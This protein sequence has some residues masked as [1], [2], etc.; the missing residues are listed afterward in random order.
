MPQLRKI[1]C[2]RVGHW[3]AR[4]DGLTLDFCNDGRP[5]DT[6]LW[7]DNGS[8]KTSILHLFFS[9]FHPYKNDFLGSTGDGKRSFDLYFR[10]NELAFVVTEWEEFRDPRDPATRQTRIVGRCIQKINDNESRSADYSPGYFFTFIADEDVNLDTLPLTQ[11]VKAG[12]AVLV[13]NPNQFKAWFDNQFRD[14][15]ELGA[16]IVRENM[17][18][19]QDHLT[20]IG[21]D[22]DVMELL[23]HLNHGEGS[24]EG[25]LGQFKSEE[26]FVL[27]LTRLLVNE[28]AGRATSE[29]INH[30][31]NDLREEP[32]LRRKLEYDGKL[33]DLV[34]TMSPEAKQLIA[35]EERSKRCEQDVDVVLSRLLNTLA[36]EK[37]KEAVLSKE[38]MQLTELA[39]TLTTRQKNMKGNHY[40]L[41]EEIAR[42][43]EG[44]AKA[45]IDMAKQAQQKA[46]REE[47]IALSIID[48]DAISEKE[49]EIRQLNLEIQARET[50]AAPLL[51]TLNNA[52]ALYRKLIAEKITEIDT[53]L[54]IDQE[55]LVLK[56][57]EKKHI[58]Q[59]QQQRLTRKGQTEATL[60]LLEQQNEER[61]ASLQQL[62]ADDVLEPDASALAVLNELSLVLASVDTKHQE[63]VQE[64]ANASLDVSA[65]QVKV[66]DAGKDMKQAQVSLAEAERKL[67][68]CVEEYETICV[69]THLVELLQE[70]ERVDPYFPSVLQQCHHNREQL[71]SDLY[72]LNTDIDAHKLLLDEIDRNHG[73]LPPSP[74]VKHV[75]DLLAAEQIP[76][77]PYWHVF[78]ENKFSDEEIASRLQKDPARYSGVTVYKQ[79]YVKQVAEIVNISPHLKSPV[80]VSWYGAP[81][82]TEDAGRI[83]FNPEF[84]LFCDPSRANFKRKELEADLKDFEK[85]KGHLG[86]RLCCADAAIKTLTIFLDRYP[87]GHRETLEKD[88][89]YRKRALAT[90]EG[91]SEL[92]NEQYRLAKN[93]LTALND[94]V[95][96]L[97]DQLRTATAR[98]GRLSTHVTKHEDGFKER[99]QQIQNFTKELHEID[100]S[101]QQAAASLEGLNKDIDERNERIAHAGGQRMVFETTLKGITYGDGEPVAAHIGPDATIERVKRHYDEALRDY[102]R[103]SQ[104]PTLVLLRERLQTS[105]RECDTAKQRYSRVYPDVTAEE[106][107]LLLHTYPD[108]PWAQLTSQFRAKA[109]TA[110]FHVMRA[111]QTLETATDTYITTK[112]RNAQHKKI[113]P[114]NLPGTSEAAQT[115]YYEVAAELENL[116]DLITTNRD[117]ISTTKD[118]QSKVEKDI[119]I[120]NSYAAREKEISPLV[121]SLYEAFPTTDDAVIALTTAK[122]KLDDQLQMVKQKQGVIL[123]QVEEIRKLVVSDLSDS[124]PE[125]TSQFNDKQ[126]KTLYLEC[127]RV[128]QGLQD[129][130][131]AMQT[132][133]DRFD[134]NKQDII[135][136]LSSDCRD[137]IRKFESINEISRLPSMGEFWKRWE[138]QPFVKFTVNSEVKTEENIRA[139]LDEYLLHLVRSEKE[140]LP[141]PVELVFGALRNILGKKFQVMTL[142]P[143]N[144]AI[145]LQYYRISAKEGLSSWSGGERLTG[146]I[147]FCLSMGEVIRQNRYNDSNFKRGGTGLLLLD[148]PFGTTTYQSF[149]DIQ[150]AL[151]KQ[152]KVQLVATTNNKD[153]DILASFPKII[154]V[155]TIGKDADNNFYVGDATDSCPEIA[156]AILKRRRRERE[157]A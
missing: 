112:E 1:A 143:N 103:E 67:D 26:A 43:A 38:L 105:T 144:K 104:E 147:L 154:G 145:S 114:E 51:V 27:F 56:G 10:T 124:D 111:E 110:D 146:A 18:E 53:G 15:H 61:E 20:S 149:V 83:V 9:I 100:A 92:A 126:L 48:A 155:K 36:A 85:V 16:K 156:E 142:R 72:R 44:E 89:V 21:F 132:R 31:R 7:G 76:A 57:K 30:H 88:V 28:E 77:F 2:S 139:K 106:Q 49:S 55:Q 14:K 87:F 133:I 29:L 54:K 102:E 39:T 78:H 75:I 90:A 95:K 113:Q 58:E 13:R 86:K 119:A 19:W 120:L 4:L 62:R 141:T 11:N 50:T 116:S 153:T 59:E 134:D 70:T 45:C 79:E 129:I 47:H 65:A 42:L 5:I 157:A 35:A 82:T 131:D 118:S 17:R 25:F 148:N 81:D 128:A 69:L 24:T 101:L 74:D 71:A 125:T 135:S 33:L 136:Q 22:L 117:N 96:N 68:T 140:G 122:R 41:E 121:Y 130:I 12:R 94:E 34:S 64:H 152:F 8:G 93:A 3:L 109:Q 107:E 127:D 150:F 73:L 115:Q 137:L 84:P 151:A 138:A 123:G 52:G 40:W 32:G 97:S 99:L 6:I 80:Q 108:V 23:M 63:K 98:R 66:S 37:K 60:R 91:S 46:K